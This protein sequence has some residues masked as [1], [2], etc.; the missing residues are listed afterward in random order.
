MKGRVLIIAGSDSSGGAGIQADIKTVTALGGFA[1]TAITAVT[2][3]NTE[4]VYG[5]HQVPSDMVAGQIK[6]VLDDIGAEIIKIGMIGDLPTAEAIKTI[7]KDNPD[8]PVVLDPVLVATSGDDLATAGVADFIRQ[9]LISLATVLTPNL[10]EA[11]ALSGITIDCAEKRD[12]AASSLLKAG[13]KAVLLKGGHGGG[14]IVEDVLYSDEQK[15]V[16]STPRLTTRNTHGTGCTLASAVATF[17]AQGKT[18]IDAVS[19]AIAYTQEAI[20]TAPGFGKGHGPLNHAHTL[21]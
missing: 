13:A 17:L 12:I 14:E 21:K 20:R 7:L 9:K 8:I 4:G 1:M 16:F 6:V 15:N 18:T 2:V 5:V 11:E 19:E 10:P 3:Q